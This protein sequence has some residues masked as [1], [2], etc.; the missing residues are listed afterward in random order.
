[1]NIL[2]NVHLQDE[3]DDKPTFKLDVDKIR[4]TFTNII[5]NAIDAMADGGSLLIQTRKSGQMIDFVFA[6]SGAGMGKE[7]EEKIFTPLYT[8]KAK[9]MGFGLSISKRIIEAHGG[10][11]SVESAVGKGTTFTI[12]LPLNIDSKGGENY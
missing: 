5:N 9:G 12:S 3:T 2:E 8:T 4:R 11:I 1:M 10:R 7:V 6:D